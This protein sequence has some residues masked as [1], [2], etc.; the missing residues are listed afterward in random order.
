MV[1]GSRNST[2]DV[3]VSGGPIDFNDRDAFLQ[4]IGSFPGD[5]DLNGLDGFDLDLDSLDN[6]DS[7][8]G[9]GRADTK[10][11]A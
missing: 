3:D 8:R 9:G 2:Y 5:F 10:R 1:L 4:L 11:T 6:F 7:L